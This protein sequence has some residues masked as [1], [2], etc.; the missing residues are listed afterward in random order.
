MKHF[1]SFCLVCCERFKLPY[2]PSCP[3]SL[4]DPTC[5]EEAAV[6][7][8][9]EDTPEQEIQ[10]QF[11]NWE[12][13]RRR[14]LFLVDCQALANLANGEVELTD[15]KYRSSMVRI[16]RH[17]KTLF[18]HASWPHRD[19]V[20]YVQWTP[21][22]YNKPADHLANVALEEKDSQS[23]IDDSVDWSRLNQILV[24]SDG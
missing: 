9:L 1:D 22:E 16:A 21:R 6:S 4:T 3:N 8:S 2:E 23:W 10:A 7:H 15:D 18:D 24:T 17:T 20:G 5:R 13:G 19:D 11:W 14:I 12:S